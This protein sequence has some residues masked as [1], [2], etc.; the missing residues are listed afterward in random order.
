MMKDDASVWG[1]LL[2]QSSG[3]TEVMPVGELLEAIDRLLPDNFLEEPRSGEEISPEVFD[4]T[5][6]LERM[7]GDTELAREV[8]GLFLSHH[9]ELLSALRQALQKK[10]CQALLTAAQALKGPMGIFA[11]SRVLEHIRQLE[12]IVRKEDIASVGALLTILE[13]E[14]GQLTSE[15]VAI[16]G[17]SDS[18]KIL[19]ADDDPISRKLLQA[20]LAKWGHEPIVCADGTQAIRALNAPDGPKVAILDWMMPGLDGVQ[21]CR[22]LRARK[23][24]PYVYV[25]LVTGKDSPDEIIE[26]LDAGADDYLVKPFDPKELQ[27]RLRA[28]FRRI[29]LKDD[30]IAEAEVDAPHASLDQVT[31]LETRDS[32]L[33]SLKRKMMSPREAGELLAILMIQVGWAEEMKAKHAPPDSLII[34]EVAARLRAA[35]ELQ[36]H[37]GLYEADRILL[38]MTRANKDGVIKSARTV[39]SALTSV[40]VTVGRDSFSVGISVGGTVISGPRTIAVGSAILATEAALGSARARGRNN[41]VF[42]PIKSAATKGTD[43]EVSKTEPPSRVDLELIVAARG[44]RLGLVGN[45]IARGAKVNARDGQGNTAL[46]EAAFFKYPDVV[47]LLLEKGADPRLR[48]IA[49]DSP[50]TEA[51]RTGNAEIVNLLLARLTPADVMANSG[52]LYRAL[53]EASSSGKPEMINVVKKYLA[54]AGLQLSPTAGPRS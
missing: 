8:A 20:M 39:R 25:V 49:G 4:K 43:P 30:L 51:L 23:E 42:T 1:N 2:Y 3:A 50:L 17:K 18:G 15:L 16:W 11:A 26:G 13:E 33:V 22:E 24:G 28:G 21:V 52:G 10:D 31:E 34:K 27:G 12:F 53:F 7:L 46:L 47:Q 45:L 35:M 32:I 48:N 29:N 40:P 9:Q 36:D 6:F 38:V 5:A 54:G 37:A 19:I 44:G 14:I 41:V